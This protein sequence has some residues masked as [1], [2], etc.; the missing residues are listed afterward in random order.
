MFTAKT[1]C[2]VPF[3]QQPLN[4]YLLL[5]KSW[6]FLWSVSSKKIFILGPLLLFLLF[7]PIISCISKIIIPMYDF[8]NNLLL[9]LFIGNLIVF[10]LL[11]RVYLGWSYILK[12]LLSATVFYEESGW[13]DGQI[14]VKTSDYLMQDRLVGLY[15]VM[16]F[17]I[18]I[19]YAFLFNV[20]NFIFLYTLKFLLDNYSYILYS[21]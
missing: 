12:R 11:L 5:K 17:I 15:Q 19:K 7:G 21:V 6:L 18:R 3:E 2:P 4:E 9:N 20:I 16:P 10:L 8:Y 1:N 13:Y 14:W